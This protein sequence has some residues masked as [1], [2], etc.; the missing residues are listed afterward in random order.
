[1]AV[2]TSSLRELFSVET[3]KQEINSN[4]EMRPKGQAAIN[5]A[6]LQRLHSEAVVCE[7]LWNFRKEK[8]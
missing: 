5:Y 1:M 3:Q 6:S 8:I 4:Q 7:L 2:E